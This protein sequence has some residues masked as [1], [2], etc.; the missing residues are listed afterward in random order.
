MKDLE[1]VDCP[2]CREQCIEL[3]SGTAVTCACSCGAM[4]LVC[5]DKDGKLA[6]RE[7]IDHKEVRRVDD[8]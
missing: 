7:V 6:R 1:A 5:R 2:E 3:G 8:K 4:L